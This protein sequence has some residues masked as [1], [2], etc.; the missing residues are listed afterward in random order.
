MSHTLVHNPDEPLW[1]RLVDRNRS[2]IYD[3]WPWQR[4]LETCYGNIRARRFVL[5]EDNTPTAGVTLFEAKRFLTGSTG[6]DLRFQFLCVL[7]GFGITQ[8]QL[9]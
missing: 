3:T 1:K 7:A 5:T 6:L 2:V 9:C 8:F 4:S